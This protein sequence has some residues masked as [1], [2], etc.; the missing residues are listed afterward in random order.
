MSHRKPIRKEAPFTSLE[1][2]RNKLIFI[3]I[4]TLVHMLLTAIFFFWNYSVL[5]ANIETG[6]PLTWAGQ[7]LIRISEIFQWPLII[8]LAQ[9][10]FVQKVLPAYSFY[11]ALF[12]NSL[13]WTLVVLGILLLIKS[14]RRK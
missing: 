4:F 3:F 13:L 6:K 11:I 5:L 12:L 10:E 9:N 2:R 7:L 8:S 14:T 1:S